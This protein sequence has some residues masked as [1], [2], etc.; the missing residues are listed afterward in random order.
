M[1][2][3]QVLL[4]EAT[5]STC[6]LHVLRKVRNGMHSSKVFCVPINRI[7]LEYINLYTSS[8]QHTNP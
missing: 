2:W 5:A 4:H 8:C 7:L 3:W 1:R 6:I